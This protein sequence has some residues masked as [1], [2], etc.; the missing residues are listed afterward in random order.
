M[1]YLG[2]YFTGTGNSKRVLDVCKSNLITLGHSLDEIDVTKDD[3]KDLNDYDGLFVFYPIYS[4]NAPKP[5]IDYVKRLEKVEK[6]KPC[7]I[8]KQSGEHLF[9]NDVSSLYLISLLKKKNI[10]V[11]NECHYLLPY[12]FVFRHTDYMAYR[13][14]QVMTKL[15]PLDLRDFFS[16][17]EVHLKRFFFDRPFA[18]IMRIEWWGGRFNGRFYEV[19]KDKCIKCMKCVNDCPAH[20]ISFKN[21]KFYFSNKCL[22]CQRCVM[23][24][25]KHAVK[26]GLFNAWRVDKPYTFKEAEY[27]K[28]KHPNYCKRS[29]I[30]Y[31]KE[32]E[33]RISK[34]N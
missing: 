18:W 29:Y 32:S 16:N 30:K 12:S 2:I 25:P 14:D 27:Q 31:F 9:W 17:K 11:T 13:M 4:F 15:V 7:F 10:V 1:R 8:M 33:E 26:A 20:N 23:Y 3:I 5:I 19:E 22:M 21:D 28:E 6:Q 34:E 24:C